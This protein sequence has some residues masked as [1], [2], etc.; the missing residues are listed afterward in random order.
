M[1]R[2]RSAVKKL[3]AGGLGGLALAAGLTAGTA[4]AQAMY[5]DPWPCDW[6]YVCIWDAYNSAGY[7]VIGSRY[8]YYG[9]YNLSNQYGLT[10][11]DDFQT[12]GARLLLC[13]GYNG[14]DCTTFTKYVDWVDLT[15]INSIVLAP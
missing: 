3:V 15:P 14:R 1:R 8:Y 2:M 6:G 4:P 10:R 11:V 9:T 5:V 12:G 7:P 13:R